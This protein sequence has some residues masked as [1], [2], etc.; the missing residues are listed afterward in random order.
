M[1]PIMI[2]L[3]NPRDTREQR[4]HVPGLNRGI[5][6]LSIQY[7]D[8]QMGE[9]ETSTEE[10]CIRIPSKLPPPPKSQLIFELPTSLSLW[11]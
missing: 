6:M 5:R 9:I 4:E 2:L 1:S 7:R 11:H 10:S 8:H 3:I